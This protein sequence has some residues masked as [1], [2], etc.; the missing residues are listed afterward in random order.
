KVY[1][2][3]KR[4]V[5]QQQNDPVSLAGI[6]HTPAP[7]LGEEINELVHRINGLRV[8]VKHREEEIK[9][10][11]QQVIQTLSEDFV[12]LETRLKDAEETVRRNESVSQKMEERLTAEIRALQTELNTEKEALQS[13][14]KEIN[15]LKSNIDGRVKQ[16]TE[17]ETAIEQAK[18]ETAAEADHT[19]Q[20]T[21]RFN[22][23]VNA[24][25]A[26]IRDTR[27]AVRSKEANITLLEQNLATKIEDF[28]K[29]LRNKE[30]L[31]AGR[32]AEIND[33]KSKLQ[34]LTGKIQEMSSFLKQAE[35]LATIEGQNSSALAAS[36]P[37][38]KMEDKPTESP[39]RVEVPSVT[40]NEQTNAAQQTVWPHFFEFMIQ[41]LA[42]IIGPK[43]PMIVREHVATLGESMDSFPKSRLAELL[44]ILSKEI[45]NEP[46]RT[47]FRVWFV[48]H[49]RG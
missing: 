12:I 22:A 4:V 23:K 41:E 13:R 11:T 7:N 24:L 15:D 42:V 26:E 14:D 1:E 16:V 9:K 39:L 17:L 28:E 5:K 44:E 37:L 31:L 10:E 49:A 36:E 38:N 48:K 34:V 35:A 25:E 43:A 27:E 32:D 29:Q 47:G 21:E 3:L 46:L 6:K 18:A 20:L 8:A 19:A 30:T 40:S 45:G 33:L 2:S